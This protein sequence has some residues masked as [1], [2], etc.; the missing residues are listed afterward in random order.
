MMQSGGFSPASL[1]AGGI[2]GA[3]YGPSDLSTLFQDSAGTTPVTTAGQPVGLMLDKSKGLGPELVT[4]GKFETNLDGW[5]VVAPCIMARVGSTLEVSRN[6]GDYHDQPATEIDL[7]EGQSYIISADAVS[8][9]GSSLAHAALFVQGADR[10]S[11]R[12]ELRR[13]T[14]GPLRGLYRATVTETAYL[15]AGV[16]GVS[17]GTVRIDNVSV[18]ELFGNHATQA[19]AAARPT[20]QTGPARATIDKVE[21]RLLVTVPTGGFTGTMVLGTDQGTASYGVN[22]PAGP[23]DIGGRGGLYFPGNAIVGQLIRDGAL[24]A[25]DAAATEADFVEKGAT[26][27]YGAVTDFRSFWRDWSE[28]TSFPLIDTSAG[29]DFSYA[30][31]S[32]T[33]LTSFPLIDTSAGTSFYRA[34]RD[35]NSLTSFPLIDTSA[36]TTFSRA[37]SGCRSL[38]SFPLI[39]TSAGTNFKLAWYGCNSLTSFP[40]IDTSAGTNFEAA[41]YDCPSLTSF[42]L[43]DTS[44]GTIFVAAWLDCSSLTSFPANAFD[45]VKGGDFA[46]AFINTEL[47]Q[48]SIDNILVSLVTSGIATGTRVFEQSGGSAPSS[49]G[50]AAIDTLR[51][52]GWT[53]A[54]TGGY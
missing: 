44:A 20:Y 47:T 41:W 13:P 18:R 38:T 9:E 46:E 14:V 33:G 21:D 53:V 31:L 2:A 36:G 35:C 43:I 48:T 37:W 52:R 1:F 28:L 49:T 16:S 45:N 27:S 32:C 29:T 54:V 26:A 5:S 12:S 15:V 34:W 25:G 22:I 30:W 10:V 51:S 17:N 3:W 6:S 42:P 24:S 50:E 11:L 7:V 8:I 23:Y 39:D 4:N 40:P 19:T